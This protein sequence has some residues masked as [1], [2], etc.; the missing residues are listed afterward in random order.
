MG[1]VK[2]ALGAASGVMSDQWKE[3]FTCSALPAEVL[4]VK[5]QKKVSG[6]SSNRHG[7]ENIITDGSI[8][9]AIKACLAMSGSTNAVMHLTA[10]AHEAQIDM[11]VL[12]EFDSLSRTTPQLA[13]MNPACN[14]NVID[15]FHDGGVKIPPVFFGGLFEKAENSFRVRAGAP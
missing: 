11:D 4:A 8:R 14:F 5:G 13:K 7:A 9:N 12:S 3:Y 15:F 6:R 10:I 1:L 2:A